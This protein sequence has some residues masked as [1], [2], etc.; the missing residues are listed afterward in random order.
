MQ[1]KPTPKPNSNHKQNLT[2]SKTPRSTGY[3]TSK[4]AQT[5]DDERSPSNQMLGKVPSKSLS[6]GSR[7]NSNQSVGNDVHSPKTPLTSPV[8]PMSAAG[9]TN[10]MN[11]K[12]LSKKRPLQTSNDAHTPKRHLMDSDAYS[13]KEN[14][15]IPIAFSRPTRR[16]APRD[17]RE[18][19]LKDKMRRKQ[20]K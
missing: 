18:P 2:P 14:D 5:A 7:K 11:V 12:K 8:V 13:N 4:N 20:E 17:L 6:F 3:L 9:N 15:N 10:Q 16:A 1:Y 19:L